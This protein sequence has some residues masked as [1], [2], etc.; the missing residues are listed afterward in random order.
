MKRKTI[1]G[2]MDLSGKGKIDS[3]AEVG[4]VVLGGWNGEIECEERQLDFVGISRAVWKPWAEK[5][6]WYL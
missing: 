4:R 3:V 1:A 2:S 6:S 5:T